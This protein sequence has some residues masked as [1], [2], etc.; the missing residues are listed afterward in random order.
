[1]Q[2]SEIRAAYPDQWLVIEALEA[3]SENDRRIFDRIAIVEACAEGRAAMK[4]YGQLHREHPHRE[5]CY[6]HT[7]KTELEFEERLWLG[8]RGL[9]ATDLSA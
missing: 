4:R 1:M 8:I 5:L 6:V 9:R 7:S 2:W 3:H